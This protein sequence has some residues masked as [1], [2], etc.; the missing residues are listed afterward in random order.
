MADERRTSAAWAAGIF[1]AKGTAWAQMK[2]ATGRYYL[3]LQVANT[4]REMLER[5][6][7][8]FGG[9]IYEREAPDNRKPVYIWMIETVDATE[10]IAKRL[11]PYLGTAKREQLQRARAAVASNPEVS[12]NWR[13]RQ[14]RYGTSGVPKDGQPTE[15]PAEVTQ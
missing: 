14:E 10:E 3:K 7:E 2:K 1:D 9:R 6:E 8:M 13:T 4:D 15:E 5:L 11:W 12:K